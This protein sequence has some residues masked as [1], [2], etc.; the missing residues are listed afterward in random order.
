MIWYLNSLTSIEQTFAHRS[1]TKVQVSPFSMPSMA[2]VMSGPIDAPTE[3][4]PSMI[5]VTKNK[6]LEDP[7]RDG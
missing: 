1:M 3:P 6:L 5:A 4:V 7:R 2:P